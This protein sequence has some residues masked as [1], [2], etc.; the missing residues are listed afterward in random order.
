MLNRKLKTLTYNEVAA[1]RP[2][3]KLAS[4]FSQVGHLQKEETQEVIAFL[5]KRPIHTV[6][7]RSMI[8]DNGIE[9]PTL[10]RGSFYGYRNDEGKLEGVALIGHTTL[11]EAYSDEAI[12]AFAW[13]ARKSEVPLHFLM[14]SG[15]SIETFWNY[16]VCDGRAPRLVCTELMF[17][18]RY[19]VLVR[20]PISHLRKATAEDL[21]LVAEAHAQV[22]FE[23]SGVNPLERDREK[24]LGRTLRRIEK[25]WCWVVVE[26]GK[27]V[28]KADIVAKTSEVIYLEGIYVAPE[29]RGKGVAPN[30]LSQIGRT[31]LAEA[32]SI[33]LLSNVDFQNAHHAYKK[34]GFK[35]KDKYQT[36]FV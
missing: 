24:F 17:E 15:D 16:Y 27:L 30:C 21:S 36:I 20:D 11:I 14:A 25:G 12:Q 31:L 6:A 3:L 28:F 4:S 7:M 9:N 22:A 18:M 2:F 1:R 26:D 13:Q 23:E 8:N 33:C 35:M 29:S 5:S 34:A 10:N 32:N 19:P